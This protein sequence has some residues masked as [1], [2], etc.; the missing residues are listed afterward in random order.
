[1]KTIQPGLLE[2][3]V[4][5]LK[6]EFEPEEIYLFGS[7]AWGD[8]HDNSDVDLFVVV[9][10]SSETPIR[11]AQRAH[12]CLRGLRMP[13]DVLVETR[14]EVERVK[15]LKSSLENIILSRGRRLYG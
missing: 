14:N 7:H 5:R 9:R 2:N 15:G 10:N 6:A 8:P 3:A 4:E 11:R 1:M 12:R 13:K